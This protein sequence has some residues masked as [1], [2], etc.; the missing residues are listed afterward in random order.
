MPGVVL[1]TIARP[2][3]AVKSGDTLLVLEA[4]KMEVAVAAPCDGRLA[5]ICV[6]EGQ[7]VGNG[8]QLATIG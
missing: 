3:D 8:E 2:G 4:M 1:R 7:H 6:S 5:E